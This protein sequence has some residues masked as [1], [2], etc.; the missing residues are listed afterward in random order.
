MNSDIWARMDHFKTPLKVYQGK[1]WIQSTQDGKFV[2]VFRWEKKEQ[3]GDWN[4][5]NFILFFLRN[6][7][8]YTGTQRPRFY[9]WP[10]ILNWSKLILLVYI[11]TQILLAIIGFI[12][13]SSRCKLNVYVIAPLKGNHAQKNWY[14]SQIL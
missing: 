9:K 10:W 12:D 5:T 13:Q 6:V 2:R 1:K 8:W 3:N 4:S 7:F 14:V 11:P